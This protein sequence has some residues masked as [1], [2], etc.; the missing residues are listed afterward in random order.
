MPHSSHFK[1]LQSLWSI[2]QTTQQHVKSEEIKINHPSSM[3]WQKQIETSASENKRRDTERR[4]GSE[5]P[6]R[7]GGR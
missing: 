4:P 6:G 7:V 5:A 3:H 1:Y 2:K